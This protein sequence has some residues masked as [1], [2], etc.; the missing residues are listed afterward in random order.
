[1]IWSGNL[2]TTV[3]PNHHQVWPCASSLGWFGD[4]HFSSVIESSAPPRAGKSA[5]SHSANPHT[6]SSDLA[7][8]LTD[9]GPLSRPS[10]DDHG[11][12]SHIGGKI[13]SVNFCMGTCFIYILIVYLA[14]LPLQP[15]VESRMFALIGAVTFSYSYISL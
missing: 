15:K 2:Y 14:L 8:Q 4:V 12:R 6:P 7:R 1:M 10:H 9:S 11:H 5:L 3:G 13:G